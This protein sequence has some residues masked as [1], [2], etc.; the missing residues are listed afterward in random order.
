[1]PRKGVSN[2]NVE[3]VIEGP[4]IYKFFNSQRALTYVGKAKNH[5]ERLQQHLNEGDIPNIR[6]FEAKHTKTTRDAERIEKTTIQ[7]S[8]PLHNIREE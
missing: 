2:K 5:K 8:K 3:K 4:G 1:M 7:R 6:Q